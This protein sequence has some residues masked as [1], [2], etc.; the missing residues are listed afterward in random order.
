MTNYC[1]EV[2]VVPMPDLASCLE[3]VQGSVTVNLGTTARAKPLLSATLPPG[4]G[5]RYTFYGR[6]SELHSLC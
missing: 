4:K 2:E 3:D 6:I 5:S 1:R